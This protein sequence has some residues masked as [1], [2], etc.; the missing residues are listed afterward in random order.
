MSK[1]TGSFEQKVRYFLSFTS[2]N[3]AC[4]Q[5]VVKDSN[6]ILLH[7]HIGEERNQEW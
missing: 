5:A 1:R 4:I 2:S 6:A 3:K 7:S